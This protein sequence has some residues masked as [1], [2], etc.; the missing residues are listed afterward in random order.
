MG[1]FIDFDPP[2]IKSLTNSKLYQR[3]MNKKSSYLFY[4]LSY[5]K[6]FTYIP[7]FF[8]KILT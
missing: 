4:L 7:D 8:K 3:R 6:N 2:Y 5:M 1:D